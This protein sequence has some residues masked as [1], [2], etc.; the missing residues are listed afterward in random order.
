MESIVAI[1]KYKDAVAPCFETASFILISR[2]EQKKEVSSSIITCTGCEGFG[3]VRIIQ[4][5]DAEVLICNGI[6]GFYR[7][8]LESAG[9]TVIDNVA[10]SIQSALDQFLQ[11]RLK[12]KPRTDE[13]AETTCSIPHKDLVCW[14]KELF[15]SHGYHVTLASEKAPFPIDMIARIECPLCGKNISVAVCCGAHMYRIDNEIREFHHSASSG[16]QAEVYIH[17]DHPSVEKRCQEF[18]IQMID[19]NADTAN[20]DRTVTG[21]IPLLSYPIPGHEKA[22]LNGS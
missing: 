18:G 14:A 11:G 22:C 19:P 4:N 15:E 12:P 9:V 7:E 10:A 5:N 2:L 17:P 20:Q 8:I 21:R 1:P 13:L 16:Y 6:K 3:R